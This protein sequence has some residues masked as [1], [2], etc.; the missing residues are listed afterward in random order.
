MKLKELLQQPK[1]TLFT[2]W[3]PAYSQGLYV[4][5]EE[6][7]LSGLDFLYVS[8]T[9]DPAVPEFNESIDPDA[10]VFELVQSRWGMYDESETF[11][12]FERSDL[13]LF[14]HALANLTTIDQIE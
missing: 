10:P 4:F 6:F 3:E 9:V 14:R 7:G 12:I 13:D 11:A 5:L 8:L 1:G 2:K